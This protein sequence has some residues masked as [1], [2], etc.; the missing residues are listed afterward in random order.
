MRKVVA[1]LIEVSSGI[2]FVL[3]GFF[4]MRV[5]IQSRTLVYLLFPLVCAAAVAVGWWRGR[6]RELSLALTVVLT[7]IPL[8]AVA[9][10]FFSGRNKP[11]VALPIVTMVFVAIGGLGGRMGVK[12]SVMASVLIV[13]IAAAALAGPQFV[14]LIVPRQDTNEDPIPSAFHLVDGRTVTS[15][16][17]RGK[18]VVLDFWATWCVPCRLELP[19]IQR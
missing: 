12:R 19:I 7:S 3:I 14:K 6:Q 17:L 10:H 1:A 9:I 18:I 13:A 15:S 16:D 4:G 11:L 5:L 8:W 2:V